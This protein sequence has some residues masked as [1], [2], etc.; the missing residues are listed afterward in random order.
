MWPLRLLIYRKGDPA[1]ETLKGISG[2]SRLFLYCFVCQFGKNTASCSFEKYAKLFRLPIK[3]IGQAVQELESARVIGIS[4][5]QG[6]DHRPRSLIQVDS[7]SV[8][9]L[10]ES[11][12]N[13]SV[14]VDE[15]LIRGVAFGKLIPEDV[16]PLKPLNRLFLCVLLVHS[17]KVGRVDDL[18]QASLTELTGFSVHQRR[19]QI[20]R[21]ADLGF[22]R[23]LVPG[24]T[25]RYLFGSAKTQYFL[26]MGHPG[27]GEYA[28]YETLLVGRGFPGD[29]GYLGGQAE[30]ILKGAKAANRLISRIIHREGEKLTDREYKYLLQVIRFEEKWGVKTNAPDR[31]STS[32]EAELSGRLSGFFQDVRV[33]DYAPYL[34]VKINEYASQ[35]IFVPQGQLQVIESV[36]RQD[37]AFDLLCDK[38]S[39][40]QEGFV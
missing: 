27:F 10:K 6:V 24:V 18:G 14:D 7:D 29:E 8:D 21:L 16:V 23:A 9:R 26:N 37:I 36:L 34:Q 30:A 2:V 19:S 17:S 40:G 22:I 25:G 11:F 35:L 1:E 31:E 20:S 39:G 12:E 15:G 38:Q 33:E 3:R 4:K 28:R 32:W 5:E 13:C